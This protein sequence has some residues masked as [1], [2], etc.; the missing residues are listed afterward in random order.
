MDTVLRDYG[1][2]TVTEFA[3]TLRVSRVVNGRAGVSAELAIRLA[4]ALDG[5]A[6]SWLNMQM[7]YELTQAQKKRRPKIQRL[8]PQPAPLTA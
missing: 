3:K 5:S 4:A 2:I 7:A 6:E 1:G 8:A